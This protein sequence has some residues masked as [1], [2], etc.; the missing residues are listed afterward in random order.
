MSPAWIRPRTVKITARNKRGRT[1]QVLY[2]RGGRG[3]RIETAGTF[4]NEKD[5]KTRRDLVAG[6]LAAGLDPRVE[7][8]KLTE[9]AAP[10]LTLTEWARRYE[11]SRVDLAPATATS[12]RS[13]V[14]NLA[15]SPIATMH[16]DTLTVADV[17]GL[18]AWWTDSATGSR[19]LK[20]LSIRRYM[21]TLRLILDFAG[22]EPNPA[23]DDRVKLPAV[24]RVETIPPTAEQFLTMLRAVSV[25][26]A[27]LLVTL[28]QTGM[29]VGEATSLEWGDVDEHGSRFRL[30][31][32]ATKTRRARWVQVPTWLME[33]V[34][35]TLPREDRTETRPVFQGL[36]VDA[37]EQ[38]MKR[39]CRNAGLPHFHPHD[40]RHR[41]GTIWHQ[42]PAVTVREQMDR[43]G[44]TRS[45]VAIDTYSHLQTLDEVPAE[46]LRALLV[47][48]P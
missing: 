18:V 19:A 34:A 29:R 8:E 46:T 37:T 23:R 3:Y 11:A 24:V 9:Q 39:A 1:Y 47:M 36:T 31:A 12:L 21:A 6:W 7:L 40:L 41:R 17:A 43:G 33:I 15:A 16:P 4:K 25:K 26:Y 35:G 30:R 48:T 5:A 38:A 10:R 2:R 22:V 28:E 45:D 27:L 13:H 42:D 14:E 32:A 20:P 44:W